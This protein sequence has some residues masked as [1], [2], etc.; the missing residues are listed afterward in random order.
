MSAV[1]NL[2]LVQ[3]ASAGSD[4]ALECPL[5]KDPAAKDVFMPPPQ[6]FTRAQSLRQVN[7]NATWWYVTT[8]TLY[9]PVLHCDDACPLPPTSRANNRCSGRQ[10]LDVR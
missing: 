7:S 5:W 6:A 8:K 9:I 1:P 2:K 10:T 4:H 3:L